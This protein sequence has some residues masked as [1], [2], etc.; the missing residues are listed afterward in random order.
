MGEGSGA[1]VAVAPAA[2]GRTGRHCV[3]CDGASTVVRRRQEGHRNLAVAGGRDDGGG[4]AGHSDLTEGEELDLA[5]DDSVGGIENHQT[6]GGDREDRRRQE[7]QRDVAARNERIVQIEDSTAGDRHGQELVDGVGV[8]VGAVD[9]RVAVGADE[10]GLNVAAGNQRPVEPGD[11]AATERH[12]PELVER[13]GLLVGEIDDPRTVRTDRE[14]EH[15]AARG[16]RRVEPESPCRRR[17]A[18]SRAR[19]GRR[20]S[21]RRK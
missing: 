15:V 6:V 1:R 14:V 12:A 8:L 16:E 5:V 10:E 2:R 7:G 20:D 21:D 18:R 17:A 13:V 3:A 9:D 11:G 4:C 19:S